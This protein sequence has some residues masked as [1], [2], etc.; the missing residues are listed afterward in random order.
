GFSSFQVDGAHTYASPGHYNIVT[1]V[2][3]EPFHAGAQI[4]AGPPSVS[5][6]D[7]QNVT[8]SGGTVTAS[9]NPFGSATTFVVNY[10]PTAAYGQQTP[11]VSAGSGSAAVA[12]SQALI[13]LSPGTTYHFQFVATN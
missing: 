5:N 12:V 3:G 6:E 8:S 9:I 11:P 13:G 1:T 7:S 10:G 2:S 4:A